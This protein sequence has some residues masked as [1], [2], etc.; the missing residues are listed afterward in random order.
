MSKKTKTDIF[1]AGNPRMN[2][3]LN[4]SHFVDHGY[5]EGYRMAGDVLVQHVENTGFDHD[6]LVYPII[7]NFRH[8][9]ELIL[10]RIIFDGSR[11]ADKKVDHDKVTH[12]RLHKLW[13]MARPLMNSVDDRYPGNRNEYAEAEDILKQFWTADPES[14]SARYSRDKDGK[15]SFQ[16]ITHVDLSRLRDRANETSKFL[17][18]FSDWIMQQLQW[19]YEMESEFRGEY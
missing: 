1:S 5:I 2:A 9:F 6:Y 14:M 7:F 11:L 17:V 18:G 15:T 8:H 13:P 4:F 10:K 16:G 19:K 3:C 12:H